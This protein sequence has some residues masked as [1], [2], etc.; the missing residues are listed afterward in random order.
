MCEICRKP[1]K[2]SFFMNFSNKF[3]F[4]KNFHYSQKINKIFL[5]FF[6]FFFTFYIFSYYLLSEISIDSKTLHNSPIN[7]MLDCF[8]LIC[9]S[10]I[11]ILFYLLN[12]NSSYEE[13]LEYYLKELFP[14]QKKIHLNDKFY[15][16]N[17]QE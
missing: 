2:K 13:K 9:L 4:E 10:F 11:F 3:R 8:M 6:G 17:K 15:I 5:I 14:N 7:Y 12:K 1:Y 16:K